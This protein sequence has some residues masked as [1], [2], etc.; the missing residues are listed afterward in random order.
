MPAALAKHLEI[1]PGQRIVGAHFEN[2]TGGHPVEPR[3]RPN[4]RLRAFQAQHIEDFVGCIDSGHGRFGKISVC[5]HSTTRSRSRAARR[6]A[7]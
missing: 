5:T 2:A 7:R 4:D 3:P 6:P 1:D